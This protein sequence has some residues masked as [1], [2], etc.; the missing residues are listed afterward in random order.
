M[1]RHLYVFERLQVQQ[2]LFYF[3]GEH[4]DE[5]DNGEG[6]Q[7]QASPTG[8]PQSSEGKAASLAILLVIVTHEGPLATV[9]FTVSLN[10]TLFLFCFI[11]LFSSPLRLSR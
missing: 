7:S 2:A 3:P 8:V 6:A 11:T 4:E 9:L 1:M 10:E 5:G